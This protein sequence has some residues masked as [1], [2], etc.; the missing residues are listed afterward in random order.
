[1]AGWIAR[2]L[3]SVPSLPQLG[4]SLFRSSPYDHY[5]WGGRRLAL[6]CIP[7]PRAGLCYGFGGSS[8]DALKP[9]HSRTQCVELLLS[10]TWWCCTVVTTT[11]EFFVIEVWLYPSVDC[12]CS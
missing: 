3:A 7:F 9:F 5:G 2:T 12:W 4:A 11:L 8:Y 10:L 6:M 1:M